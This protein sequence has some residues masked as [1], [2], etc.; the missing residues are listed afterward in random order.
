MT[1][2]VDGEIVPVELEEEGSFRIQF[3]TDASDIDPDAC[4]QC[5]EYESD[6]I[7][8]LFV[9]GVGEDEIDDDWEHHKFQPPTGPISWANSAFFQ[10][11]EE[12]DSVTVGISIGDPR[13]A[14][15]FQIRRVP[16]DSEDKTA[17]RLIMHLP[18]PGSSWLH[19]TLS[20]LHEG[21]YLIGEPTADKLYREEG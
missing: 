5:G 15:V 17:G 11:D 20:P 1:L 16:A 7:H 9:V 4:R 3:E 10:F 13:G 18:Y 6:E 21:T 2:Y 12:E 19:D 8:A 14:F